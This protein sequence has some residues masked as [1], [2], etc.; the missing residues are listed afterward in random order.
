MAIKRVLKIVSAG[1]ICAVAAFG[2][3]FRAVSADQVI[4]NNVP[5]FVHSAK[6]VGL[7]DSTKTIDVVIWLKIRNQ[8]ALDKLAGDLYDPESAKYHRWI[9]PAE[10][11]GMFAPAAEDRATVER[12]FSSNGL[13]VVEVGAKNMYVRARGSV[14]NVNRAFHVQLNDFQFRGQTLYAN[15]SEPVITGAAGPLTRAVYG[16]HDLKYTHPIEI[17]SVKPAKRGAAQTSAAVGGGIDAATAPFI[18]SECFSR[19]ETES[20][21]NNADS[22]PY[23]TLKGAGYAATAGAL[24][25]CGY[26]PPEIH[27]AYNLTKLYDEGYDG[28]G[29]TIVI[30]DWCGSPTIRSDANAFSAAYGLPPLTN[31]SIINPSTTPTCGAPD[32]E[33]NLDVEWA[34][35]IAPGATIDLVVPPS[36]TFAD[37][38]TAEFFAVI[39]ALGSVISGSYGAE[40]LNLAGAE[41]QTENLINEIAAVQGISAN[42]ATGDDGDYTFDEPDI[43]PPSVSAPAD[44]PYA[45]GVGGISLAL[46]SNNTIEWQSGWGTNVTPIIEGAVYDPPTEFGFFYAGSGGGPSGVFAKPAF[47]HKLK[48]SAR[49]LPDISWLAD[50]F[51][52]GV[53]LISEPFQVP[54]QV[55]EIAGGTSLACPMFS[56]LWAIANQEAGESLGQA[57]QYLYSMPASTI[58]D[59]RPVSSATNVTA[60]YKESETITDD[61]KASDLASPLEGTREFVS[62]I[63]NYPLYQDTTYVLT[64]GTDSSLKTTDGWDNVTGVGV[65]KGKAFADYF[66]P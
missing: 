3:A 48:G 41:V 2:G 30:I 42:F 9:K 36:P 1:F 45:T 59:V 39:N 65:P 15:T 43:F 26:T 4:P 33:I 32:P 5:R 53:I 6:H 52:G 47:Q 14:A 22:Y 66:H 56:A 46:K 51:T 63:W 10:F 44:S 58:I 24:G 19:T 16:L 50:P 27:A 34:H 18:S 49:L 57:A 25:G 28:T 61:Y 29:Q 7:T 55:Y 54:A 20:F 17:Q 62:A 60:V 11:A 23:V 35:A 8:A 13:S 37:V 12:F 31:F 64:F 38:D 21:K 40:E